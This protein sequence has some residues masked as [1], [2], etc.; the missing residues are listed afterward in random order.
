MFGTKDE[1]AEEVMLEGEEGVKAK[2]GALRE[3]MNKGLAVARGQ[4]DKTATKIRLF[5]DRVSY[6]C[7]SL[8][9]CMP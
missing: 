2:P 1:P 4:L 7:M 5:S 6:S 9:N 8:P 3:T